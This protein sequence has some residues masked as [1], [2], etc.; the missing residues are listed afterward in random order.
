M[1]RDAVFP[2]VSSAISYRFLR[3]WFLL[4]IND[5]FLLLW[6]QLGYNLLPCARTLS[7]GCKFIICVSLTLS[8]SAHQSSKLGADRR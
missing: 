5:R 2:A 7:S 3:Q 6:V 1:F 4:S 8:L